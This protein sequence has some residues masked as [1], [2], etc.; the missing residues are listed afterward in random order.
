MIHPVASRDLWL[1][2]TDHP[3][4]PDQAT[5]A[6]HPDMQLWKKIS[7]DVSWT[8]AASMHVYRFAK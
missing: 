1:L 7:V 5:L 6:A 3:F 2:H 4:H 8:D